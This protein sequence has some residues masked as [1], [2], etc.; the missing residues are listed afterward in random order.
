M[1]LSLS[2]N[3]SVTKAQAPD[4]RMAAETEGNERQEGGCQSAAFPVSSPQSDDWSSL[5]GLSDQT[6]LLG[7]RAFSSAFLLTCSPSDVG[8]F[9]YM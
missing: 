4:R 5:L 7:K 2:L 1:A 9:V 3:H 6:F 8:M